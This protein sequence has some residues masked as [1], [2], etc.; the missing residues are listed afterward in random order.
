[1]TG[2][3]KDKVR[4]GDI[5]RNPDMT[6]QERK[7]ALVKRFRESRWF[8]ANPDL[9]AIV[10]ELEDTETVEEF[11]VVWAALYDE[12]DADRVW[13]DRDLGPYGPGWSMQTWEAAK[14]EATK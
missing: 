3:W 13:I 14:W 5:W 2:R 9:A 6:Q 11:D 12:A 10:E 4:I 1:M 7:T 8:K